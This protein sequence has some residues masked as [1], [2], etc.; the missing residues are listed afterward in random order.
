MDDR[1][2]RPGA[3]TTCCVDDSVTRLGEQAVDGKDVLGERLP[4]KAERSD[5]PG[6]PRGIAIRKFDL[7]N[8]ASH[9]SWNPPR[10]AEVEI[11]DRRRKPSDVRVQR[12]SERIATKGLVGFANCS[13]P[14]ETA[15]RSRS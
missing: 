9:R 2:V 12:D 11:D 5:H 10:R 15:A 14:G 6:D 13:E 3:T 8:R 4:L 7:E 1:P